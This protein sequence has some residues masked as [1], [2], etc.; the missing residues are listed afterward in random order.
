MRNEVTIRRAGMDDLGVVAELINHGADDAPKYR[1][2]EA[3]MAGMRESF[4]AIDG[5]DN[6]QLMVAVWDGEVVG[7]FHVKYLYFLAGAGRPDALVEAVHVFKA[8]RGRGVGKAMMDWVMNAARE[9]DCR[10]IQLTSNKLRERAHGFY[11]R[12][13]F[14]KSH[15]GFRL[16]LG[17]A[18]PST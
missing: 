6:D 2:D 1:V 15:D 8:F 13:G 4:L 10:R 17:A 11:E 7:T 5:S 9:R 16:V 3:L 18:A 12:L 14:A